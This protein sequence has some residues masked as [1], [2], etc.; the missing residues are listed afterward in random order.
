MPAHG[1][2]QE[3][4]LFAVTPAPPAQQ[5]VHSHSGSLRG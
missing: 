2:V 4:N 3:V 5:Q 1:F